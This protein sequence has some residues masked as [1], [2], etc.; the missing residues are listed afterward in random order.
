[1]ADGYGTLGGKPLRHISRRQFLSGT[2]VALGGA[3]ASSCAPSLGIVG[4][5][6]AI[7]FWNLFGGGDGIRLDTMES[8]FRHERSHPGLQSVTLA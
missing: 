8:K 4:G 5:Q 7:T 2:A 3:L 6:P 1:M